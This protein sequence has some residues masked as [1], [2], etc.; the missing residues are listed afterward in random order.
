MK[1]KRLLFTLASFL[2]SCSFLWGQG[3]FNIRVSIEGNTEFQSV[4]CS[5]DSCFIVSGWSRDLQ[6]NDHLDFELLRYNSSGEQTA[7]GSYSSPTCIVNEREN[8]RSYVQGIFVQFEQSLF[9]KRYSQ[10]IYWFDEQLDTLLTRVVQSPFLDSAWMD[11]DFMY[12]Q[13][14]ILSWDTCLFYSFGVWKPET[15]GNDVCIKKLSPTGE[16]IWTYIYATAAEV[17]A[18]YALLPQDDGGVIAGIAEGIWEENPYQYTRFTKIDAQGKEEWI[19]DSRDLFANGTYRAE[20]LIQD[21]PYLT[22]CGSFKQ[23]GLSG[24]G[25]SKIIKFDFEGH[26]IWQREYGEYTDWN[27]EWEKLTNIVQSCDGNY[28]AGGTWLSSPGS[29]EIIEGQNNPDYDSFAHIVKLDNESGEIIWE[30][31]YRFLEIYRDKHELVDMKATLDGGVIFCG[32]ARD[33]YQILEDPIQQGWLVKLD[34]CGC[35]V[36]GC[37]TL[38][39]YV[40]CSLADT[41][42]FPT[43]G[44]HFIVGPNPASQFINI[45]FAGGALDLAQTRFE[46]YDLRGRLVYTFFPNAADTTYMLSTEQFACGTYVLM[47]HHNG[48]KVQDKKVVIGY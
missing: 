16:E 25:K 2:F 32:E 37:D 1:L 19:I 48:E 47:L 14:A 23:V 9:E 4:N 18:C 35:L 21:G 11:S 45:Y 43:F 36:P 22:S 30:R 40:G 39:N 46:M 17:D 10:T 13:Y 42:L 26:L 24:Y 27:V 3:G 8:T 15:T 5:R 31:K 41:A 28:V 20:C 6:T 44:S 33:S 12:S 38:C 34:E 29:E 7:Q